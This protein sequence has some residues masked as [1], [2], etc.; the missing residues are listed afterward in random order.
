M[1]LLP[2]TLTDDAVV[3][4]GH[5][6]PFDRAMLRRAR[7]QG[8]THVLGIRPEFIE[9][10]TAPA[11]HTVAA[12]VIDRQFLGTHTM[13]RAAL[14]KQELWIKAS[15]DAAIATGPTVLRMPPER[16]LLYADGKRVI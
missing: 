7:A 10:A 13:V 15:S 14:G 12:Q 5:A 1:N 11:T 2:C 4:D 6:L 3:V 16:A 8:D 9:L